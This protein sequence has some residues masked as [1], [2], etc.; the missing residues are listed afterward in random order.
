MA[1]L[2]Y[3]TN[4]SM[5]GYIEDS[6]GGLG[7]SEPDDELFAFITDLVR[8]IGTFLYGRRLYATM[9]VWETDPTLRAQSDLM[10]DFA[11]VWQRAEKVVYSASSPAVS[12][13][14]TTLERNFDAAAVRGLKESAAADLTIGGAQ[15]AAQ[16]LE[17]GIVDECHLF[18]HPVVI[19]GGKPAFA[20]ETRVHLELLDERRVGNGIVYVRYHVKS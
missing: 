14:K 17:A 13:A 10:A 12:T 1:K 11:N 5:D 3:V 19:G 2:L 16:A 20:T 18:V 4:V 6:Q 9:A 7:W 8:P 15:L